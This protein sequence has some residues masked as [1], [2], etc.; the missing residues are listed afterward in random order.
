MKKE[1]YRILAEHFAE[2]G[3]LRVT[4]ED[5]AC[6]KTDGKEIILPTEVNERCVNPLL[7][8]ILH[9]TAHVKH[10]ADPREVFD[11]LSQVECQ[12]VNALEDIRVD[13][14]TS[15]K[16]PNSLDFIHELALTA[17]DSGKAELNKEP[18][19]QQVLKGLCFIHDG[20]NPADIYESADVLAKIKDVEHFI[21]EARDAKSTWEIIPIA[22]RLLIE[23]IGQQLTPQQK[24]KLVNMADQGGQIEKS[25][26]Q[27]RQECN[28]ANAETN[29]LNQERNKLYKE[30]R[31]NQRA[32][33]RHQ[34]EAARAE[35]EG[36]KEE[37]AKAEAKAAGKG[38]VV[39][40]LQKKDQELDA[41]GTESYDRAA[42]AHDAFNKD[43]EKLEAIAEEFQELVDGAGCSFGDGLKINGFDA[44][45]GSDLKP[46]YTAALCP[47]TIQEI[48]AEAL[49]RK[50]EEIVIDENGSRL[51][52]SALA[53]FSTEPEKLFAQKEPRHDLTKIAFVLDVSGSMGGWGESS[54]LG[55]AFNAL[56]VLLRAVKQSQEDGAPCQVSIYAFGTEPAKII[57]DLEHY[58]ANNVRKA[59]DEQRYRCG[60]GTNLLRAV[61]FVS[62]QLIQ[63]A[64]HRAIVLI[65]D[66]SVNPGDCAAI[67][68]NTSGDCKQI[69]IAI[70]GD[71]YGEIG[72]LFGDNNILK[73]EDAMRVIGGALLKAL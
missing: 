40:L 10:T 25:K 29:R 60:S 13:Y 53:D 66:A 65:T 49:L 28:E 32:E 48:I 11:E 46:D 38:N 52:Q 64:E 69:Y 4:F 30:M 44:L 21:L 12:A 43:N 71:L 35:A 70:D 3:G 51:N 55:Q 9:E 61:N 31:R 73:P 54:R 26:E 50:K 63:E 19:P 57:D 16:Y 18:K 27:H 6:P 7:G 2:K 59:I 72:A 47:K 37:K 45:K 34:N 5:G 41:N 42:K 67:I 14:L 36:N 20:F 68:N 58:E 1:S 17:V 56:D 15:L 24:T 62:E 33:Y 23:L 22:R 39:K 8:A